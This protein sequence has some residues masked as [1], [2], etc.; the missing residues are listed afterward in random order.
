MPPPDSGGSDATGAVWV[1][2]D[3]NWALDLL[4][5]SDPGAAPLHQALQRGRA[6]WLATAAMRAELARVLGYPRLAA[7][8]QTRALCAEAVLA[9][10][11]ILT[12]TRPAAAFAGVRCRDADDQ[13]FI[14]LA[15]AH[16]AN[17]LS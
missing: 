4:L 8:M 7:H 11:D 14:D 10:F 13:I 16:R 6:Q 5:F 1:V 2:I 17:L 12:L 15:V 3:T 9:A